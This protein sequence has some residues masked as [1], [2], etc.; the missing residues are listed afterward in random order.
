M[1]FPL[2]SN[3][4]GS[5]SYM[6][7]RRGSES[8]LDVSAP[9]GSPVYAACFGRVIKSARDNAGGYG[10]NIIVLCTETGLMVWTGHHDKLLVRSGQAVTPQTVI[11]TVGMTG[12]TG[13]SHIH[14]TLRTVNGG[15]EWGRP[16]IE[17][18]W[19][20]QQFHWKPFA[21]P[22]GEPWVW[23][24][25]V[26]SGNGQ[27][28]VAAHPWRVHLWWVL[29]LCIVTLLRPDVAAAF[30]GVRDR[31]GA[32]VSGAG[33]GI[34]AVG[35]FACTFLLLV[36]PNRS[37][38]ASVSTQAGGRGFQQA[39]SFTKNW[40]GWQCTHDPVRTKGG[41]TQATYSYYL[42]MQE[43]RPADVCRSLT[44]QQA[45]AIYY[46]LYWRESGAHLL[47]WPLSAAHYDT[48]VGSG[49]GRAKAMLRQC[50]GGSVAERF[51]CYQRQRVRFYSGMNLPQSY[52]SAWV[53]RTDDLTRLV[54]K[55]EIFR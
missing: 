55:Q 26:A 18:Y 39:H 30:I 50:M 14:V 29:A 4:L 48:A 2:A 11:G 19:P 5:D 34:A 53:R 28:F 51:L 45:E 17:R 47:P 32:A 21:S 36:L 6:H 46:R 8:A 12:V 20:M 13:F 24:G 38:N 35:V 1:L 15:G 25:A 23:G 27:G 54:T 9:Q 44:Q 37:V 31:R 10:H 52:V 22:K 41:V 16:T 7:L 40:E 43:L 42:K 3:V 49:P 33:A